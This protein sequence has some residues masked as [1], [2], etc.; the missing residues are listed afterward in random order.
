MPDFDIQSCE[1]DS[2]LESSEEINSAD[3]R[4]SAMNFLARREHSRRELKQKLKKRFPNEELVELELQR[5][6]NE[7]LQN[8][9]RFAESFVRQRTGSGY[10]PVRTRQE[11]RERGISDAAISDTIEGFGIDWPSVADQAYRKK[12]GEIAAI[13]LKE[14]AKRSRFM[15]YR[16]FAPEHYGSLLK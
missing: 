4:F 6:A 10:G 11:L 8:D 2:E 12:Y 5:L 3:I 9:A 14:K 1:D 13:D 16:G 7:N 15:Q